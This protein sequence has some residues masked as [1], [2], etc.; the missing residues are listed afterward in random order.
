[1]LLAG[2]S[3][4]WRSSSWTVCAKGQTR[5]SAVVKEFFQGDERCGGGLCAFWRENPNLP[6]RRVGSFFSQAARTIPVREIAFRWGYWTF[7]CALALQPFFMKLAFSTH[8]CPPRVNSGSSSFQ[9]DP[10]AGWPQDTVSC[11]LDAVQNGWQ[12]VQQEVGQAGKELL[13]MMPWVSRR[14]AIGFVKHAKEKL[15]PWVYVNIVGE[16]PNEEINKSII[17]KPLNTNGQSQMNS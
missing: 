8:L 13:Q 10:A 17:G 14:S 5:W 1:M 3:H 2:G 4:S 7:F 9:P 11:F 16:A 15:D 6:P 12:P